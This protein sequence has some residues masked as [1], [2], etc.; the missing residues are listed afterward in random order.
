MLKGGS[1]IDDLC[2]PVIGD[3]LCVES[4]PVIDDLCDPVIGDG[5]CVERWPS[6]R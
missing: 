2:D 3:D 5:L 4:G 1:V 6:D